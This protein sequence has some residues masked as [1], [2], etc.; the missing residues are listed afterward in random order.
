MATS[1]SSSSSWSLWRWRALWI[2]IGYYLGCLSTMVVNVNNNSSPSPLSIGR[3]TKGIELGGGGGLVVGDCQGQGNQYSIKTT[4]EGVE[5][6]FSQSGIQFPL[7]CSMAHASNGTIADGNKPPTAKG[8][9]YLPSI[10][11]SQCRTPTK[12]HDAV[13]AQMFNQASYSATKTF[14]WCGGMRCKITLGKYTSLASESLE[15]FVQFARQDDPPPKAL[16]VPPASER[17]A[18]HLDCTTD[19]AWE[20]MFGSTVPSVEVV[21]EEELQKAGIMWYRRSCIFMD[22]CDMVLRQYLSKVCVMWCCSCT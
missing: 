9:V 21:T 1:S 7:A 5:T 22:S 11:F 13:F 19:N 3:Y 12:E 17:W 4:D 6:R 16:K 10:D 2:A 20:C 15:K 18:R 8:R 14:D